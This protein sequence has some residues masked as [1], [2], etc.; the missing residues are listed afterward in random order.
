M[1]FGRETGVTISNVRGVRI[2]E[3]LHHLTQDS[4]QLE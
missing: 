4:T 3:V 1:D 2:S